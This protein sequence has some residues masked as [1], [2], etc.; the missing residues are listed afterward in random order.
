MHTPVGFCARPKYFV[1]EPELDTGS[2]DASLA[3]HDGSQARFI[4]LRT[5]LSIHEAF[6]AQR[7]FRARSSALSNGRLLALCVRRLYYRTLT[8]FPLPIRPTSSPFGFDRAMTVVHKCPA[9]FISGLFMDGC[10]TVRE[11]S[12]QPDK[13]ESVI[14]DF[15]DFPTSTFRCSSSKKFWTSRSHASAVG[16]F[17]G[18]QGRQ[19]R[20]ALPVRSQIPLRPSGFGDPHPDAPFLVRLGL[21]QR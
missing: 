9:T 6:L 16:P 7:G 5:A 12:R 20:H 4:L 8:G 2:R 13:S 21:P 11:L 18:F 17:R 14:G 15:R 19:H 1:P 3:P 10:A